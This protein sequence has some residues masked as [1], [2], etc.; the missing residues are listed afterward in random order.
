MYLKRTYS[1]NKQYNTY[2]SRYLIT[3]FCLERLPNLGRESAF[4][5]LNAFSI[6]AIENFLSR[7]PFAG[8]TVTTAVSAVWNL[9][10]GETTRFSCWWILQLAVTISS[11][12]TISTG[13]SRSSIKDSAEMI[14]SKMKENICRSTL[15][16]YQYLS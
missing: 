7:I 15:G 16:F 10:L 2:P 3:Y 1:C 9:T 4:L 5:N 8:L 14:C 12:S 6:K 11:A 13:S